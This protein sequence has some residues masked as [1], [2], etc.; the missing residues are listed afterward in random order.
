MLGCVEN[1]WDKP[2]SEKFFLKNCFFFRGFTGLQLDPN[3]QH[4]PPRGS[5]PFSSDLLGMPCWL[6]GLHHST[7]DGCFFSR[8]LESSDDFGTVFFGNC[9]SSHVSITA[10]KHIRL[11]I[12]RTHITLISGRGSSNLVYLPGR[13]G[14]MSAWAG[15]PLGKG[16]GLGE[17]VWLGEGEPTVTATNLIQQKGKEHPQ[18]RGTGK[19]ACIRWNCTL[20]RRFFFSR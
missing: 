5:H 17:G 16:L 15:L 20:R 12:N 18:F 13:V 14:E 10:N 9:V 2:N 19:D 11:N 3:P 8:M 7:S 6:L 4:P 1:V